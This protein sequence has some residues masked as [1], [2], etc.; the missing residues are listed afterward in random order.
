VNKQ[1]KRAA[2]E[3]RSVEAAV[4]KAKLDE[5]LKFADAD[6]GAQLR[7]VKYGSKTVKHEF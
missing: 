1:E 4:A 2:S 7:K 6:I 5:L 3:A